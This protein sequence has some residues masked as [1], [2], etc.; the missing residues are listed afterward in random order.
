MKHYFD[1]DRELSMVKDNYER[2]TPEEQE[3]QEQIEEGDIFL[4]TTNIELT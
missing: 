2:Y 4:D 1:L 3:E